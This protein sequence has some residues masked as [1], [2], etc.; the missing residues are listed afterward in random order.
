MHRLRLS[1]QWISVFFTGTIGLAI[2]AM[3][4][5]S[6]SS[7]SRF[8]VVESALQEY[9]RRSCASQVSTHDPTPP[10]KVPLLGMQISVSESEQFYFGNI[11]CK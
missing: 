9:V 7:T 11:K 3:T 1:I 8:L 6:G 5:C 2:K 10:L 4:I